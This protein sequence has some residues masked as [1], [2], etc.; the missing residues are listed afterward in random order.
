MP[1]V[2]V[3][4]GDGDGW[5]DPAGRSRLLV[6][7]RPGRRGLAL[8]H[9]GHHRPPEGRDPHPRATSSRWRVCQLADVDPVGPGEAGPLTPCRSSHGAGLYGLSPRPRRV[10][11]RLPRSGGFD[12]AKSSTS[13]RAVLATCPS[14]RR[15]RWSARLVGAARRPART[16]PASRPSSTAAGRCT[17]RHPEEAVVV[18][19]DRCP[20][21]STAGRAADDDHRAVARADHHRAR[22]NASERGTRPERRAGAGLRP[23]R[24]RRPPQAWSGRSRCGA[25]R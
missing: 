15:R 1:A 13:P 8:L 9:V 10:P 17:R 21:R 18:L 7:P 20:R 12:A 24:G 23:G 11:A 5:W 4:D 3:T 16:G 2:L 14:S 25:R 22:A 19:G 6:T